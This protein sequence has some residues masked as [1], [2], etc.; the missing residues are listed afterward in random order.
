MSLWLYPGDCAQVLS[1]WPE[2]IC[3]AMVTDPPAGVGFM[4]KEWDSDKGGRDQWVAWLAGAMRHVFRVLKPGAHGLVWALPRT[5]HWTAWAMED[6]GFDV[7]DRV[8]HLFGTGF[9]KSMNLGGGVGTALKPA[10]EDWWLVRKP[11]E[12]TTTENFERWGTGGLNID[13]CRVPASTDYEQNFGPSSARVGSATDFQMQRGTTP[14]ALGRW[15]AHL[16]LDEVA[17]ASLDLHTGA[18]G[19]G[20]TTGNEPSTSYWHVSGAK[21]RVPSVRAPF[22]AYGDSGGASRFFYTA[23]PSRREKEFGLEAFPMRTAGEATARKDGSAGLN[24]P[25]AGAGRTGG[26]RNTHPTVK[27]VELMRYL[28]RLITPPGGLVLDPFMGSGTTGIAARL[29]GFQFAGIE[30]ESE[31]LAIASARI[32]AHTKEHHEEAHP[33]VAVAGASVVSSTAECR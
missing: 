10:I 4:N 1:S 25:R 8:S 19:S 15:P 3:D 24:S 14:S 11:P 28:C 30:Q 6:A 26:V 31:Y 16:V 9:P 23:K 18:A 27:P 2:N 13:A 32:T 33:Q 21:A 5:S 22:V 20:S 17:A 7:R 29:E 12:N